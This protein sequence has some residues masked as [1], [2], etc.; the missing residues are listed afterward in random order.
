MRKVFC[1]DFNIAGFVL[2]LVFLTEWLRSIPCDSPAYGR[3]GYNGSIGGHTSFPRLWL[4][5]LL[6]FLATLGKK[7][8][9]LLDES[10]HEKGG[11]V[12]GP[13]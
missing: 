10:R 11:H 13:V 9:Q 1:R 12:V 2:H 7:L 4:S 8:S 5:I 6:N 3:A